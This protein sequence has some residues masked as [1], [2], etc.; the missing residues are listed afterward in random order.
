[1]NTGSYETMISGKSEIDVNKGHGHFKSKF[2][3][4]ILT[5]DCRHNIL[6]MNL[7]FS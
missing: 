2:K 6:Q 5:L 3:I 4:V 1:M 7:L